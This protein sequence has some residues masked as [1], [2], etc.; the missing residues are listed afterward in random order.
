MSDAASHNELAVH[1]EGVGKQYRHFTLDINLELPRAASWG[2]L[3]RMAPE[4]RPP[5][6]S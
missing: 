6:A 5:F 1:F 3:G 2:L 4:S